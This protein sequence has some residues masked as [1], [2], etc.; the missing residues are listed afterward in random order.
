VDAVL[1]ERFGLSNEIV[2]KNIKC[3]LKKKFG[4]YQGNLYITPHYLCFYVKSALGNNVVVRGISGV[5]INIFRCKLW[6]L[7]HLLL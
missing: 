6:M 4:S 5:I 3:T 1:S 2:I 7:L